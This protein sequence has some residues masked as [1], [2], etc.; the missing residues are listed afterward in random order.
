MSPV[1]R[2]APLLDRELLP[3]NEDPRIRS[4]AEYR[5]PTD[6]VSEFRFADSGI[7]FALYELGIA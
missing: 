6:P 3:A 1:V 2:L 4:L 5:E 7:L